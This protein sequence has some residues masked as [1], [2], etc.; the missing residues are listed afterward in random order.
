M[1]V[2]NTTRLTERTNDNGAATQTLDHMSGPD[3]KA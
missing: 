2:S 3:S 1:M